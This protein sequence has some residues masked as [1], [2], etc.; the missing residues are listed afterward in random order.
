LVV[1]LTAATDKIADRGRRPAPWPSNT[2]TVDEHLFD[3]SG[4]AGRPAG[5]RRP[6]GGTGPAAY[7]E[8]RRESLRHRM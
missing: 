8:P 2:T 5:S 3:S 4:H 7:P 1:T 6:P